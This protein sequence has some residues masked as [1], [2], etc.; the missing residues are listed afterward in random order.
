M[1]YEDKIKY[2]IEKIRSYI[3]VLVRSG[4]CRFGAFAISIAERKPSFYLRNRWQLEKLWNANAE[5]C[6][7]EVATHEDVVRGVE[8]ADS[9]LRESGHIALKRHVLPKDPSEHPIPFFFLELDKH[10]AYPKLVGNVRVF[11]EKRQSSTCCLSN[12]HRHLYKH[13]LLLCVH[14]FRSAHGN[15][16]SQS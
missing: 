10:K 11:S 13:R 2:N 15:T 5:I 9:I 8:K 14:M 1:T 12:F 7:A 6:H 3:D 4:H 16:C